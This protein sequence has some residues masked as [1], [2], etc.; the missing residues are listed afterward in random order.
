MDRPDINRFYIKEY[1]CKDCAAICSK[2]DAVCHVCGSENILE[3]VMG[4][5]CMNYNLCMNPECSYVSHIDRY[6]CPKCGCE[7]RSGYK[8]IPEDKAGIEIPE[9]EACAGELRNDDEGYVYAS[10]LKFK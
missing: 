10:S 5:S 1:I 6:P 4:R 9:I 2:S 8:M 7:T 3:V